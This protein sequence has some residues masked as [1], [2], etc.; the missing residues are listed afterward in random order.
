MRLGQA[1]W[2]EAIT[3][4]NGLVRKVGAG[5][6]T[7]RIDYFLPSKDILHPAPARDLYIFRALRHDACHRTWF[8]Q[9]NV[10]RCDRYHIQE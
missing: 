3:T 6:V 10:S 9:G 5:C 4:A 7:F 2:L 1:C 8:G